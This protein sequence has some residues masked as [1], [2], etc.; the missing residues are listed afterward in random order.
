MLFEDR[1][2]KE[3]CIPWVSL[4]ISLTISDYR[5]SL[6]LTPWPWASPAQSSGSQ[7]VLCRESAGYPGGK[8]RLQGPAQRVRWGGSRVMQRNLMFFTLTPMEICVVIVH[9]PRKLSQYVGNLH[10][11]EYICLRNPRWWLY[12]EI[13]SFSILV[14]LQS[15]SAPT[16]IFMLF[17]C[18]IYDKVW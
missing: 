18:G 2:S 17:S 7:T 12:W 11:T 1:I 14:Q 3:M 6:L 13:F 9:G 5:F 15:L 4:T 10:C 16:E 8:C